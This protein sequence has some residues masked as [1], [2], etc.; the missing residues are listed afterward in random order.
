MPGAGWWGSAGGGGAVLNRREVS[1]GPTQY[2]VQKSWLSPKL[3]QEPR[4]EASS[5]GACGRPFLGRPEGSPFP[6]PYFL[7][8]QGWASTAGWLRLAHPSLPAS[9]HYC[10]EGGAPPP[11]RFSQGRRSCVAVPGCR[12]WGAPA[13]S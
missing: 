9:V 4:Q 6:D 11:V 1:V 8:S 3:Q 10:L 12:P 13:Q 7:T 2:P 5:P